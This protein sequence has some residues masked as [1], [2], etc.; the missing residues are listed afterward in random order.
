MHRL[1]AKGVA[2]LTNAARPWQKVRGP[3]RA[4][5]ATRARLGWTVKD[6]ATLI[7]D[8]GKTLLLEL[9]PPPVVRAA[10][11]EAVKRWRWRRVELHIPQLQFRGA[12]VGGEMAEVW[13]ALN[14][15]KSTTE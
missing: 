7:T 3:G 5:I 1:V 4:M 12:G 10:V 13:R 14:P 9:D 8:T 11:C 2:I 6:A 15:K